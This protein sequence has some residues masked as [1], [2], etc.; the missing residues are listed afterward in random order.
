MDFPRLPQ[1]PHILIFD[2]IAFTIR[3]IK[4]EVRIYLVQRLT[5]RG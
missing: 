2:F 5:V 3:Q 1:L 4:S